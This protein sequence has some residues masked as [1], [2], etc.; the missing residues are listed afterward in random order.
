ME[1]EFKI[2]S[3]DNGFEKVNIKENGIWVSFDE[4]F[5]LLENNEEF[6]TQLVDVLKS[7]KAQAFNIECKPVNIENVNQ[8][9]EFVIVPCPELLVKPANSSS[10]EKYFEPGEHTAVFE[11]LG[12]DAVL[13]SPA[14][15]N[16]KDYGHLRPFL[17]SA[18]K[19]QINDFLIALG[20][21]AAANLGNDNIYINTSGLGVQ[22]LH[23]RIDD[24]PKY[25]R[26]KPYKEI[27]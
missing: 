7:T 27:S 18:S 13:I 9:F 6:R 5:G 3:L 8:A 14:P 10:F 21:I 24:L 20:E 22:W 17:E 11:N 4:V 19:E 1:F 15:S 2:E 23:L 26:F 16:A 12:G 25:Y